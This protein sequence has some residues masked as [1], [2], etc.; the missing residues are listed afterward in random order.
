[1]RDYLNNPVKSLLLIKKKE[2]KAGIF[3]EEI[4]FNK[5]FYYQ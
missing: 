3:E 5:E 2:Q 4:M 1:M